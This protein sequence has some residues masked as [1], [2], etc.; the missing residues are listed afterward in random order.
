M[1]S[2]KKDIGYLEALRQVPE[3]IAGD[4]RFNEACEKALDGKSLRAIAS[5]M[6]MSLLELQRLTLASPDRERLFAAARS[7]GLEVLADDLLS[8]KDKK[9]GGQELTD[10]RLSVFSGNVKWILSRRK[11][12]RYSER[13]EVEQTSKVSIRDA[14]AEARGRSM[15]AV[16]VEARDRVIGEVEKNSPMAIEVGDEEAVEV[17]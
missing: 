2:D 8:A 12:E 3:D 16:E 11:K 1:S 17:E 10:A 14:L 5:E 7:D 9:I 6:D 15:G 4:A 13:V